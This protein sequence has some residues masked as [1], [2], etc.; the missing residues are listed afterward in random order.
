VRTMDMVNLAYPRVHLRIVRY[1]NGATR[2]PL[3]P[4]ACDFAQVIDVRHKDIRE[5]LLYGTW[6]H[7][8]IPSLD[9]VGLS[10]QKQ[11][12]AE[13]DAK[14]E[15]D[16]KLLKYTDERPLVQAK[17]PSRSVLRPSLLRFCT[18]RLL[19]CALETP[20]LLSNFVLESRRRSG[21]ARLKFS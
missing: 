20:L 7:S 17:S 11:S 1:S 3:S 18:V 8:T 19:N 21:I 14:E 16:G 13:L 15:E 5:T 6:W 2:A 10:W 12:A 9:P 4:D